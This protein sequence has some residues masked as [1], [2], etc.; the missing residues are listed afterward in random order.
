MAN[1][2]RKEKN[3]EDGISPG[4]LKVFKK[5]ETRVD[6]EKDLGKEYEKLKSQL[7]NA[8]FYLLALWM[9]LIFTIIIFQMQYS[10]ICTDYQIT[11]NKLYDLRLQLEDYEETFREAL[12]AL[13]EALA[14]KNEQ[15]QQNQSTAESYS[16]YSPVCW[17]DQERQI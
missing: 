2:D 11:V 1:R 4:D 9:I 3:P 16:L 6:Q 13:Q 10:S 17:A 12:Q 8:R 15:H 14:E 7:N 5:S